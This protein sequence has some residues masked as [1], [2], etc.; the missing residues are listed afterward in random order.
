MLSRFC[1]P[2]GFSPGTW[3]RVFFSWGGGGGRG[4]WQVQ[5][6]RRDS[7][8]DTWREFFPGRIP[9]GKWATLAESRRDPGERRVNLG[10]I[11]ARSRYLF[12]KG[13]FS[14]TRVIFSLARVIFSLTG[15]IFSLIREIFSLTRVIFRL[16]GVIFSLTRV[17][18]SLTRVIF[19]LTEVAFSL[20]WSDIQ[21]NR[22]GI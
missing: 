10:G 7:C 14:L 22:S 13:I 11:P 18:F 12:Y 21:S 16:T 4:S 2:A 1:F 17:T 6:S 19:S 9:P 20:N 8:Q 3:R 5:I 15:A